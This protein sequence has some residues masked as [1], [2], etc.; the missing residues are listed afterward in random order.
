[1]PEY[2]N[3]TDCTVNFIARN[4]LM[5]NRELEK[6]VVTIAGYKPVLVLP[7]VGN[8]IATYN[9]VTLFQYNQI[10]VIKKQ[11]LSVD[12]LPEGDEYLIVSQQY[13]QACHKMG[14]DMSRLLCTDGIVYTP[15]GKQS[16]GILQL[17]DSL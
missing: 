5:W 13:A 17:A 9:E 10:R 12:P 15:D 2:L 1:M 4:E 3:Y 7:S 16:V 11:L 14:M 8:L 6:L